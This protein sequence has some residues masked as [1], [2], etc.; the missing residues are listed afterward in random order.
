M[1]Y[2]VSF[3]HWVNSYNQQINDLYQ[4]FLAGVEYGDKYYSDEFYKKFTKLLYRK[5]SGIISG[6]L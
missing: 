5:S 4:I 6:F 2:R 3:D 1:H